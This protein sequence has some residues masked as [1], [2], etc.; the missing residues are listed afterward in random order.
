MASPNQLKQLGYRFVFNPEEGA[1][2]V[3]RDNTS[4][5]AGF[6]R[7]RGETKTSLE[8]AGLSVETVNEE[9]FKGLTQ[10]GGLKGFGYAKGDVTNVSNL[11][12]ITD[13][14]IDQL[15]LATSRTTEGDTKVG[16]GNVNFSREQAEAIVGDTPFSEAALAQQYAQGEE[17]AKVKDAQ[18]AA[19]RGL[20]PLV[21]TK[22]KSPEQQK[23]LDELAA[24]GELTGVERQRE[25]ES[26]A[27]VKPIAAPDQV[28]PKDDLSAR[29]ASADPSLIANKEYVNAVF[30]A[31]HGRDANQTELDRFVGQTVGSVREVIQAGAKTAFGGEARAFPSPSGVGADQIQAG[32]GGIMGGTLDVAGTTE[33]QAQQ[34]GAFSTDRGQILRDVFKQMGLGTTEEISGLTGAI[35]EGIVSQ[36]QALRA[37]PSTIKE[38][39]QNVGVTQGQLNRLIATEREPV[40]QALKDLLT[41]RSLLQ[42]QVAFGFEQAEFLAEGQEKKMDRYAGMLSDIGLALDPRTGEIVESFEAG[43]AHKDRIFEDA[44]LLDVDVSGLTKDQFDR[45]NTLRH[46][47][48][49]KQ[50]LANISNFK[51]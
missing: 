9:E 25:I 20:E 23:I 5:A 45:L 37:L 8:N 2:F 4:N 19:Q 43:E 18:I 28:E 10:N 30:K 38:R 27:G 11:N 51:K 46:A 17:A 1:V 50:N 16:I 48:I 26:Q 44:K 7:L 47:F 32:T 36:E 21:A 40:A 34:A 39:T 31:L 24:K 6:E 41:S 49:A 3:F 22:K 35:G 13:K 33:A 29:V 42:E 12:E 14:F 15:R